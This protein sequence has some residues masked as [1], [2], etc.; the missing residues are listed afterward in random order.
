M[1]PSEQTR[2]LSSSEAAPDAP[3]ES[4]APAFPRPPPAPPP[5]PEQLKRTLLAAAAPGA[6]SGDGNKA[7][8]AR[9]MLAALR[10]SPAPGPARTLLELLDAHALDVVPDL[11]AAAVSTVI[12]CGYPYAL[13]LSVEDV[14]HWRRARPRSA[15]RTWRRMGGLAAT[16]LSAGGFGFLRVGVPFV[17]GHAVSPG[18][19]LLAVLN[20]SLLVFGAMTLSESSRGSKAETLGGLLLLVSI[21]IQLVGCALHPGSPPLVAAL[22]AVFS[23]V[24]LRPGEGGAG[25]DPELDEGP[26]LGNP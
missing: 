20:A 15:A 10:R 25:S 6:G 22:L 9:R 23:A 14:S 4:L 2:P 1:S 12:G 8:E 16:A 11:R 18:L 21:M 13:E 3:L 17:E 19:L 7:R 26:G 24:A 5:G